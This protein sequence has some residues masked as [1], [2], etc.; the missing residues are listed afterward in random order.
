MYNLPG[1]R[2][3]YKYVMTLSQKGDV[4]VSRLNSDI[5]RLKYSIKYK[6][7]SDLRYY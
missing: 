4:R 6:Q 3:V 1:P 7:R 2:L 5:V